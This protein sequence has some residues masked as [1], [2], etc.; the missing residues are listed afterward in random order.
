MYH[1]LQQ[2]ESQSIMRVWTLSISKEYL[3]FLMASLSRKKGKFTN[4]D[5]ITWKDEF[6]GQLK[7]LKSK[8]QLGINFDHK[9]W[10]LIFNCIELDGSATLDM[11]HIYTLRREGGVRGPKNKFGLYQS[12][13]CHGV[14]TFYRIA[15]SSFMTKIWPVKVRGCCSFRYKM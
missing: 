4:N 11:F 1:I 8:E 14:T 7:I 2:F 12:P 6:N 10:V 5:V 15:K 3:Y 13:T 9:K